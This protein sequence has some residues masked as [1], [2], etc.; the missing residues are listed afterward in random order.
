MV[1]R[2]CKQSDELE[3]QVRELACPRCSIL[4]Y[5]TGSPDSKAQMQAKAAG[6]G[7]ES[8][9]AVTL[10]G[11]AVSPEQLKEGNVAQIVRKLFHE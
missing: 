9:P 8:W 1:N 4:V 6:Y 5:D 10:D 2:I 11:K 3:A 7:I